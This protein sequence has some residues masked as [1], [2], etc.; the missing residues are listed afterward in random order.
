MVG[1]CPSFWEEILVTVDGFG[2]AM[3][4]K[5]APER[6]GARGDTM[7]G[8]GRRTENRITYACSPARAAHEI[9]IPTREQRGGGWGAEVP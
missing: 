4:D 1:K 5:C 7:G 8:G 9:V 3:W 2:P 6:A